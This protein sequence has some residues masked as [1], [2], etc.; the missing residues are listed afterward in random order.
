MTAQLQV[1]AKTEDIVSVKSEMFNRLG[2][3][4]AQGARLITI[5]A[6]DQGDQIEYVYNF[7]KDLDVVNLRVKTPRSEAMPS[8]SSVYPSAFLFENELQDL[9]KI[10]VAGISV[11]FGGKLLTIE[12]AE[13]TT[14]VKP[15][16]GPVPFIKRFYGRCR[17]ECP[18]MV[19]APKYIRQIAEGNPQAG[20][21][22]CAE[23]AP[24]P[25]ILGR[26]C[27]APCQEGCRQE[28]NDEYIQI[29]LL[30]RFTADSMPNLRRNMKRSKPTVRRRC[31]RRRWSCRRQLRPLPRPTGPRGHL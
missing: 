10:P 28:K 9:F 13:D 14:L 3:L 20:Y 7:A 21:S 5:T 6:L 4:K 17:E 30:K 26:V 31:R 22:T 1:K 25:A 16:V 24:L 19:N 15:A 8:I 2:E 27:F 29:R 23:R 11:D 18:G 12:G